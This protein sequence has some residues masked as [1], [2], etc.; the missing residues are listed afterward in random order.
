MFIHILSSHFKSGKDIKGY[1]K[2]EEQ[3]GESAMEE[4]REDLAVFFISHLPTFPPLCPFA[5]MGLG[6]CN[7]RHLLCP[8]YVSGPVLG[9]YLLCF[10]F[11]V[12]EVDK[13]ILFP[14]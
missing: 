1:R 8:Y 13:V 14:Q 9:A 10:T 7:Y 5:H 4:T 12:N 11:I 6:W 3:N 2:N